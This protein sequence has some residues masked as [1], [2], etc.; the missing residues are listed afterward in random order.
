LPLNLPCLELYSALQSSPLP[1]ATR[2]GTWLM[3]ESQSRGQPTAAAAAWRRLPPPPRWPPWPP[4]PR[5]PPSP[6][7]VA[8]VRIC[9][10]HFPFEKRGL[11]ASL[12]SGR[13]WLWLRLRDAC[14]G[15]GT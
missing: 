3:G 15:T 13:L 2:S 8:Q 7:W 10:L 11:A 5:L 9:F 6:R 14:L 4:S 1:S 12:C